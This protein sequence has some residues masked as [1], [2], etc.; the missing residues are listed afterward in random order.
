MY[1][2]YFQIVCIF[3]LRNLK[4]ASVFKKPFILWKIFFKDFK[5][6]LRH[7]RQSS[8]TNK[9]SEHAEHGGKRNAVYLKWV[10][11]NTPLKGMTS[12]SLKTTSCSSCIVFSPKQSL[13]N[14]AS[15]SRKA[16]CTSKPRVKV[17]HSKLLPVG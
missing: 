13:P 4:T 9:T 16:Y 1:H 15:P 11:C 12:A 5:H 10:D 3:Q 8:A 14:G 2:C 7:I 6:K 17:N